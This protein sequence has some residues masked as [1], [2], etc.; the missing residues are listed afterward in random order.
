MAAHLQVA[1]DTSILPQGQELLMRA[2]KQG[3]K[4][5]AL[6]TGADEGR[7]IAA[8]SCGEGPSTRD[9]AARYPNGATH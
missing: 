6:A 5:D 2:S 1:I 3:R 9:T 8:I 7:G 4:V